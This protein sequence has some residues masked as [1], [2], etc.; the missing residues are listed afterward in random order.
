MTNYKPTFNKLNAA[1]RQYNV[2]LLYNIRYF[3]G[4][5]A[6]MHDNHTCAIIVF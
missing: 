6:I 5:S 2:C 4:E 3:T 1:V